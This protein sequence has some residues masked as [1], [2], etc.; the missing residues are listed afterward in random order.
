MDSSPSEYPPG[1]F[2]LSEFVFRP[3]L[4]Y[5]PRPGLQD[6]IERLRS[7]G[8]DRSALEGLLEVLENSP[9]DQEAL[10]LALIVLGRGRTEQRHA[11]EVIPREYLLD[12]R[13]DP[14]FA[15]CSHCKTSSW[16][17]TNC[18]LHGRLADAQVNNPIGLQCWGC[19]YVMCR[20]CYPGLRTCPNCG[21]SDHRAP[22]YPTGRTP[23][24]LERR[25]Q[26]VAAT[27]VF[28]EGPLAPDPEW[29]KALLAEVSPDALASGARISAFPAYP[30]PANIEH[31]ALFSAMRLKDEGRL[32]P[33]RMDDV[34]GGE[35]RSADGLRVYVLKLYTGDTD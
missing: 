20:K 23:R 24:Q 17:P 8:R 9:R 18:L 12:R 25:P 13:L 26:P 32:P 5:T 27:L 2:H 3:G 16:T 15:V 31:I 34:V 11:A 6:R 30:W 29:M 1:Q 7:E 28:R 19:G 22:V 21:S 35:V 33:V 4:P 10:M 14:I